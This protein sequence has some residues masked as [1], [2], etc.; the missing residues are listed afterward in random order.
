VDQKRKNKTCAD[1]QCS[2]EFSPYNSLQKYCSY[3][4]TVKNQKQKPKKQIKRIS[5]FSPKR[6]KENALYL[7]KRI[8]FL[9]KP[10]NKICFIDNCERTSTTIEHRMGREGYADDW[11]R[12]N[13]ITLYLD[14]RYWAGC[15]FDH[16]LQLENDPELS[17][18][19]QLSK[20]HGGK[21]L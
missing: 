15:C 4:C 18:K 17:K 16:N 14:E 1:A 19:Y 21:K 12:Q 3:Q 5:K 11:A 7:K 13:G 2:N 9:E 6:K 8:L 10:E 20:L